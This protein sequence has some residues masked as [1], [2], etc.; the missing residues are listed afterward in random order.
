MSLYQSG[1]LVTLDDR[2][3]CVV[4]EGSLSVVELAVGSSPGTVSEFGVSSLSTFS[5]LS[6]SKCMYVDCSD[7]FATLM[8]CLLFLRYVCPSGV[9]TIYERGVPEVAVMIAGIH[10]LSLCMD[11]WSPMFNSFSNFAC[12]S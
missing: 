9:V 3:T 1:L 7:V 11:T 2:L 8:I 4:D 12:L 5:P 10:L 6:S